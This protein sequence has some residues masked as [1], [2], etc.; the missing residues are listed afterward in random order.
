MKDIITTIAL[1]AAVL[2]ILFV[3]SCNES[4]LREQ[5]DV[6]MMQEVEC[7]DSLGQ[8]ADFRCDSMQ[9]QIDF[10]VE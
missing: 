5:R 3:R 7:I 4:Y 9:Q 10:I 6:K 1:S 2:A 8:K